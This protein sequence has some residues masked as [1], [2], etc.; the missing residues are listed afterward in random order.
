MKNPEINENF[1]LFATPVAYITES[2]WQLLWE[3]KTPVGDLTVALLTNPSEE[4]WSVTLHIRKHHCY[5]KGI[6]KNLNAAATQFQQNYKEFI[7]PLLSFGLQ[8]EKPIEV[9]PL[10][11]ER[12]LSGFSFET[13]PKKGLKGRY[14]VAFQY[15]RAPETVY[16]SEA[17]P[18]KASGMEPRYW[19]LTAWNEIGYPKADDPKGLIVVL[20]WRHLSEEPLFSFD[21][22]VFPHEEC[23]IRT[24]E[25]TVKSGPSDYFVVSED[26]KFGLTQISRA[27]PYIAKHKNGK[28]Y[29]LGWS[30]SPWSYAIHGTT[31]VPEETHRALACLKVDE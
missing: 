22:N 29:S 26:T 15:S 25:D 8:A 6:G 3:G 9:D 20:A 28:L 31:L 19:F 12:L 13:F 2:R 11:L 4:P 14:Q 27:K 18:E 5:V 7:E 16:I 30:F 1:T 21:S 24:R 10:P 17:V 23:T